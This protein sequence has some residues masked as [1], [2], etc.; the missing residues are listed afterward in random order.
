MTSR[1]LIFC[2]V[3]ASLFAADLKVGIIGLDTSHVVAFTELLNNP[4]NPEHVAGARVVA[5]YRGG[6]PDIESSRNRIDKFTEQLR[7]KYNVQIVPDIASLLA[8]VDVV[9][10][11]SVDGRLHLE[12]V[13][14]VFAAKKRVFIDK[15][16]AATLADAREI[17]RL[18]RESGTPWFSSSSLRYS[19]QATER[20][21][22]PVLGA[23]T[24]GPA[25][26]EP[27][28]QL[29]LS[30]YGIHAI[31]MLYAIMGTGCES[32]TRTATDGADLVVG[33]WKDGR[34]GAVRGIR[35]GASDYGAVVYAPKQVAVS[36][37]GRESLYA[38]L[39]AEVVKFFQTGVP[40]VPNAET[41]EIFAFMDAAQRSKEA[42]GAPVKVAP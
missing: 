25:P 2:A 4:A 14:P 24:W 27:H 5:G 3:S 38:K 8:Q 18:G 32:V 34:I 10:L 31:E 41:L 33:R 16:L 36:P 15:P 39:L 29:D 7:S 35:Q 28:H 21:G 1:F 13:R 17:A 11:E 22:L 37:P 26:L 12:Q 20:K 30:W 23:F 40:P 9:L 42:S 19:K 6:S